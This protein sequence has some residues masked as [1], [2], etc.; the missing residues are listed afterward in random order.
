[1]TNSFRP[2]AAPVDTFVPPVSVAPPTDLD[3]LARALKT[4]NPGLEAFLD[5][6]MDEAI[7]DEQQKGI[8]IA[9]DELLDDGSVKKITN[10][11]KKKDGEEAAN[12]L[13]GGSI[14]SQKAYERTKAKL[15]GQNLS[16]N[17]N[18]NYSSKTFTVIENG[19]E[20]IRPIYHFSASSPEF[21][22][23][24][25]ES[26][27]NENLLEGISTKYKN[28]IFQP[29]QYQAIQKIT[30]HHQKEHNKYN[31]EKRKGQLSE[32][33]LT[34]YLDYQDGKPDQAIGNIQQYIEE[35][36]NLGLSDVVKPDELIEIAKNHMSRIYEINERE[37]PGTGYN[38][39]M[40]YL[41]MIGQIKHGPK[42]LQKDGTY[43]QRLL[44]DS[45]GEDILKYKVEL[46]DIEDK[47]VSREAAKLEA[48]EETDIIKRITE[49]PNNYSVADELLKEYPN[50]REF[51][52][53]QIEIYAGDRDELFNDFNYRVGTGYY[54]NDRIR[55][56]NDLDA[57]KDQIG[58]TWTDEDEQRFKL[59]AKIARES[60]SKRNIGSFEP[61][62]KDMHRDVRALLGAE[63]E[64][65][66]AWKSQDR[67]KLNSFIELK[68][69]INRRIMDEITLVPELTPKERED[70]FREIQA[71]YF[72]DAQAINEGTYQTKGTLLTKEQKAKEAERQAG[73]Q[74]LVDEHGFGTEDATKIYD[75]QLNP[76]EFKDSQE[77][78]KKE[79]PE[80]KEESSDKEKSWLDLFL[81][82]SSNLKEEEKETLVGQ[83]NNAKENLDESGTGVIDSVLNLLMGSAAAEQQTNRS[84][85]EEIDVTKPFTFNSL[86]RLAQ[87]VGFSPED[88][89][90]AAA[91]ALAESSGR[92]GIDTVQSG[93]D[94]EKKNEFSLGLWQ[95]DMQDSPGYMLG[96]D[97]R[98]K[99]GIQSNEELYNPLT[100]AK[101]A[102]M[103]FD[104]F[105]F[106]PW[107]TYTSGKYKD[108]L[109]KTD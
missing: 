38:A 30:Q 85:L 31:I 13:I 83:L 96:T 70:R 20:V 39:A 63:G 62:I 6:K 37:K 11:V 78:E 74:A 60:V 12:Q 26:F 107:A 61:R 55:M 51:L 98:Q 40:N 35:T 87:E 81:K 15:T 95:I 93:L 72:K 27:N 4:V 58:A 48:I 59:S 1:M 25:A 103:I 104:T 73:I 69:N 88:A 44:V 106:K 2:Q 7:E 92:A 24:L 109:P 99:F 49:N 29:Y 28:E 54:G 80:K 56:F 9:Y 86:E 45:L 16:T 101:A 75:Q 23:F 41:N 66:N 8:E 46:G 64:D 19:Q 10:K 97:R 91:I 67:A 47:L 68:N 36:V 89:R 18:N 52:F 3:V 21:Q 79:E 77:E 94:P 102:K 33:L 71:Q 42:E 14:F 76:Q 50:R 100:N 34:N 17:I 32:V 53:D 43:K 105:G 82:R 65:F 57:I 22:S 84:V 108:F 90:I 5:H